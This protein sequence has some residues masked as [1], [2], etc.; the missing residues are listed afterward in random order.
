MKAEIINMA[1]KGRQGA[2]WKTDS[3]KRTNT[4]RSTRLTHQVISRVL[5]LF[6][7]VVTNGCLRNRSLSGSNNL[8]LA[9][10]KTEI[11]FLYQIALNHCGVFCLWFFFS[12]SWLVNQCK[13][14][15]Y[16][17]FNKEFHNL[18][19]CSNR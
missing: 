6:L 3:S 13:L 15:E 12:S 19:I 10:F 4:Q 5:N 1:S 2:K 17:C 11:L 14:L 8:Q 9:I 18:V 7:T 16:A